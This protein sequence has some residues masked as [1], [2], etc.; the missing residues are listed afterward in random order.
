MSAQSER[1]TSVAITLHWVIAIAI[2]G[3]I[4]GGWYMTDLP[5]GAPGQ[6]F[7][8]QM[9]KSVGITILLLSIARIIWRVMNPP[10][11]LPDDIN[12]LEKTASHL[13]HLGFYGLMILL[14]LTGWLYSS[15]SVKLDVP[16]V[17]YFAISW[18]DV[19]FVEGLK[20]EAAS[21]VVNFIHS[22]LAW[23]TLALLALHVAGAVKHELSAEEG[24]L[25]RMLPGLFGKTDKPK[26]PGRGAATAF[27]S[28]IGVL[29]A[30]TL[31][32]PV[33]SALAGS[34]APV[35]ADATFQP[36]WIVNTE[37][38][39]ITFSGTHDG[40]TFTGEFA[41]WDAAIQFDPDAPADAEVRVTVAM[42]NAT[43]SQKLYEDSLP[44]PEWFNSAAFPTASVEILDITSTGDAAYTSTAR[45]TLKDITVDTAFPFTLNINDDAAQ[46]TGQAV[47]QRK[48]LDLGQSSDPNAD[49][50]SEDI[51]VDVIVEATRAN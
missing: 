45:L 6:Y 10:P 9:H 28:A 36:N 3:M 20:T 43:A 5:D 31:T 37:T 4:F 29:A 35:S 32:P 38:S 48:P 44:S 17:L 24:V 33:V 49:W 19:P 39:S 18:P 2:L 11:A 34:G 26:T 30:V 40:N 27:G 7:L 23:V 46:M 22:K 1:Y 50:V 47:F 15:V 12:G 16:T 14:P 13:V 42:A 51:T 21:G 25:K 8:Y 41:N